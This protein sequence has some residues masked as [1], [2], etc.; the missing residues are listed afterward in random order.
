MAPPATIRL[1]ALAAALRQTSIFSGLPDGDLLQ[2]A[3]YSERRPLAKGEILFEEGQPVAGFYVV[4][5]G[6]IKAYRV[7]E[8]GREQVI[9]LIPA[10][11]S[12]A[13]PA[14]AG[15]PGYPA[16]TRALEK[17]EVILIRGPEFLAHLRVHS[18]LALRMLASLSRHLHELVSTI[19]SHRLQDAEMRLLHWL[20]NRCPDGNTPALIQLATSKGVLA[21]ELGTRPETLSRLLAK[22]RNAGILTVCGRE[23]RVEHPA[24]LHR[25]FE[26]M[27]Q[28]PA[29]RTGIPGGHVPS[30]DAGND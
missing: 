24:D 11:Q 16:H 4:L 12:F 27:F 6:L 10:G 29:N 2:I 18:E 14:V 7:D 28:Q 1:A 17:S 21:S 9:H 25:M 30:D 22:L 26:G 3:G 19:E 8:T 23:I 13:E 15:L 20:A 5:K